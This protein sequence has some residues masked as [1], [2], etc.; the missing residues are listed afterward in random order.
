M[1]LLKHSLKKML[2]VRLSVYA[3]AD[4]LQWHA[5]LGALPFHEQAGLSSVLTCNLDEMLKSTRL[6]GIFCLFVCVCGHPVCDAY[7]IEVSHSTDEVTWKRVYSQDD[8]AV[9]QEI[10]NVDWSFKRADYE[11]T[12]TTA[13]KVSTMTKTLITNSSAHVDAFDAE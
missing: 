11:Q 13:L 1:I 5:Y 6:D 2:E 9:G 4:T 10:G 8:G 3:G 12:I 7:Y